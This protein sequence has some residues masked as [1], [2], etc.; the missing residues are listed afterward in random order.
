MKTCAYCI[1]SAM[2]M[3]GRM[4]LLVLELMLQFPTSTGLYRLPTDTMYQSKRR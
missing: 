1:D 2:T 3:N 4:K